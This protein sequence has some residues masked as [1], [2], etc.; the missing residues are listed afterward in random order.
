MIISNKRV[1]FGAK[2][3]EIETSAFN[4]K[5]STAKEGLLKGLSTVIHLRTENGLRASVKLIYTKS[6][7]ASERRSFHDC[8]AEDINKLGEQGVQFSDAVNTVIEA[9]LK[10]GLLSEYLNIS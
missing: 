10:R 8:F 1:S 9:A 6:A 2:V 3:A 4:C 7:D 5:I